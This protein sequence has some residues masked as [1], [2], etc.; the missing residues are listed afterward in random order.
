MTLSDLR[1]LNAL[2]IQS[3]RGNRRDRCSF[4]D[5]LRLF[6]LPMPDFVDVVGGARG[7]LA[8]PA[9]GY[10]YKLTEQGLQTIV[11]RNLIEKA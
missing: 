3:D 2:S 5:G 11:D 4:F 8:G 10:D 1:Y 7:M 9:L 6:G